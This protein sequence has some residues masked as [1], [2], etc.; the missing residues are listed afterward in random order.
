MVHGFTVQ[1]GGGLRLESAS[2]V[3]TCVTLYLPRDRSVAEADREEP[4]AEPRGG[5]GAVLV[6]EDDEQVR[7]ISVEMLSSLGY[8]VHIACD[9]PEALAILQSGE[10]ID[11]LFTDLVMPRGMSGIELARQARRIKP[12]LAVLLT[13]GYALQ[14]S[15]GPDEF[16]VIAKPLRLA[17]LSEA[18]GRLVSKTR[19]R[20]ISGSGTIGGQ[21][22]RSA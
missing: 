13:T 15:A 7:A 10:A 12:D 14:Q 19:Q 22:E 20:T 2:G 16:P 11:L 8:H 18:V 1:S 9:G 17:V 6:V 5:A 3:G 21:H 4:A